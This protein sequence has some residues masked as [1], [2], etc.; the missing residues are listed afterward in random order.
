MAMASRTDRTTIVIRPE[1]RNGLKH[2]ARKD[3]SYNELLEEM[4]MIYKQHQYDH[5][6]FEQNKENNPGPE[7]PSKTRITSN[8]VG[9]ETP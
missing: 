9:V 8:L 2:A 7:S 4:L 5:I 6:F 3:Q 1:I